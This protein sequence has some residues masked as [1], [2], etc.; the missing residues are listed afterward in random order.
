[1][2]AKVGRCVY[3]PGSGIISTDPELL[4]IGNNVIFGFQPHLIT[5]DR[6]GSEKIV[7]E[8]GGKFQFYSDFDIVLT[9]CLYRFSYGSRSSSSFAWNTSRI[10]GCNGDRIAW[11]AQRRLLTWLNLDWQQLVFALFLGMSS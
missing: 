5:T 8:D 10:G 6:S 7:I 3:W 11:E 9:V 4:D 2:G 1:M